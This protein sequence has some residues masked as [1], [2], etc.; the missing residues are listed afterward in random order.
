MENKSEIKVKKYSLKKNNKRLKEK[1]TSYSTYVC[2]LFL[3]IIRINNNHLK[4]KYNWLYNDFKL[5]NPIIF[6][7]LL[8]SV[9]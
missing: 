7:L 4:L 9:G 6:I 8:F 3:I 1:F 2:S 5:K